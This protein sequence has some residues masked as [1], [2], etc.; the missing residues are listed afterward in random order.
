MLRNKHDKSQIT[1]HKILSRIQIIYLLTYSKH[2]HNNLF[3][4]NFE[5]TICQFTVFALHNA[6]AYQIQPSDLFQFR[7]KTF[8]TERTTVWQSVAFFAIVC[9]KSTHR[10]ET[11]L[12]F[13]QGF[14]FF[15]PGFGTSPL[16]RFKLKYWVG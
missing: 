14:E 10:S 5:F 6:I 16:Q 2:F 4:I 7:F 8:K 13:L 15:L 11:F 3:Q 12:F 1:N 9:K